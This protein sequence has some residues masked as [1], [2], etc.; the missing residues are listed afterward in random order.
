MKTVT[1]DV[2][3]PADAMAD[4]AQAWKTGKPQKSARI[5]FASPELL[6]KALT[7]KRWQLLKLLC[8]AGPVSIRE[9]ARRAGRDVKAVHGDVT[10][11]LN[12]GLL[13]RT[14]DG[15]IVFPYEAV[16]VEFLLQAT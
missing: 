1:L 10:A 3:A 15:R 6:W 12:A 8:G 2:R 5:S 9:A 4:F 7:E 14:E 13:D 11:L 16:K